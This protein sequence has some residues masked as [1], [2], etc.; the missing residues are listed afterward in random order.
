MAQKIIDDGVNIRK[1][2][3][4]DLVLPARVSV[5]PEH[6]SSVRFSQAVCVQDGWVPATLTDFS[7]GGLGFMVEVYLPRKSLI[8]VR[9]ARHDDQENQ[10]VID[11]KVRVQRIQMTDRR[12]AFLVGTVYA[13]LTA[14]QMAN[15]EALAD[16]MDQS[17]RDETDAA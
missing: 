14:Q 6:Q 2:Q 1:H 16:L 17:E 9:V 15:I 7:P 13:D 8:R 3:R 11:V 12:P 10:S 4:H 5:A